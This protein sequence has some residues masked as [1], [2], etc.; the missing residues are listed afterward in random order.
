WYERALEAAAELDPGEADPIV[1]ET[2]LALGESHEQVGRFADAEAQYERSL[3]AA[4]AVGDGTL[5]ARALAALAHGFWLQ[6]RFED[7]LRRQAEAL[8]AARS[9]G[10]TDL[11]PQLLY[12][13]GTL[14]FGQGRYDE[15]L[16]R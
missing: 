5:E 13:A 16:G 10:A 3:A 15:A 14:A 9:S 7:G 1:A 8:E 4:R 11:L 6:D 2:A 12:T